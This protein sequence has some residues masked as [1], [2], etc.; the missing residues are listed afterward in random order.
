MA[1]MKTGRWWVSTVTEIIRHLER[2]TELKKVAQTNGG[3][4]AGPCP[5]CGG[6][7]R[8]RVWPKRNSMWCRQCDYS[9]DLI[10]YIQE[11]DGV[12]FVEACE[13]LGLDPDRVSDSTPE[14][15]R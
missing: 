11:R 1:P 15:T 8:F 10:D 9:G 5:F 2:D 12:G 4:Y 14:V 13:K 3:E 6:E 7:D